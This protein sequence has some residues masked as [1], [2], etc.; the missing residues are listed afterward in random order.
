MTAR[1]GSV[2]RQARERGRL[3]FDANRLGEARGAFEAALAAGDR[4]PETI[5]ALQ[6]LYTEAHDFDRLATMLAALVDRHGLDAPPND[7]VA[8]ARDS[9]DAASV[10]GWHG[11]ELGDA[12]M[13]LLET[14][15]AAGAVGWA[16]ALVPERRARLV[17]ALDATPWDTLARL[18]QEVL[19][20]PAT[21]LPSA[22]IHDAEALGHRHAADWRLARACERLLHALGQREAAYRVEAARRAA[23]PRQI[24]V[25][26][27]ERDP[28]LTGLVVLVVGGHA[29]L[30]RLIRADLARSGVTVR[31]LP[32]AWEATR[33]LR[34]VRDRLTGADLAVLIWRQLAHST[35]DRVRATADRLA[36]PV[37]RSRSASA[38]AVRDAVETFQRQRDGAV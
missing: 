18:E 38:S 8:W 17:A 3:A 22:A 16:V 32:S 19:A 26:M 28:A 31:E 27:I 11:R 25:S 35:G 9:F 6:L 30:R 23:G 20:P 14:A 12:A 10:A 33:P 13:R 15:A 21:G 36:V 4:D 7:R 2:A 29:A 24:A 5:A 1:L 34:A 37:V